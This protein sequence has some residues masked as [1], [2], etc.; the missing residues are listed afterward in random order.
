MPTRNQP[1]K[2]EFALLKV[3]L[4]QIDSTRIRFGVAEFVRIWLNPKERRLCP[5][6]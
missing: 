3:A 2:D 1:A 6:A 5:L 4:L